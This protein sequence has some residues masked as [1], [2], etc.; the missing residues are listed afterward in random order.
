MNYTEKLRDLRKKLG[1]TQ[2][3]M[4]EVLGVTQCSVSFYER[5]EVYP[6]GQ[7]RKKYIELARS[8]KYPLKIEELLRE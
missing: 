1:F 3:K 4:A 6:M 5:G 2:I 7:A 8:I